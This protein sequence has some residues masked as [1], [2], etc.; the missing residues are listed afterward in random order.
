M[1]D[2]TISANAS[3][4]QARLTVRGVTYTHP[5]GEVLQIAPEDELISVFDAD[6]GKWVLKIKL[7]EP[8]A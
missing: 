2:V 5:N 1:A 4:D 3:S 6:S 7:P 8:L